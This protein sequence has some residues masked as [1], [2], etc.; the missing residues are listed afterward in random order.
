MVKKYREKPCHFCEEIFT[1]RSSTQRH[2]SILCRFW[3]RVDIRNPFECWEWLGPRVPKGYGH[4]SISSIRDVIAHRYAWEVVNGPI[5][6]DLYVLHECDNRACCNPEHLWLGTQYDNVRD[7]LRKGRKNDVS[8]IRNPRAKLN[9]NDVLK[10]K[11]Q[12]NDGI[13]GCAIALK[14][15]VSHG[16]ISAIKNHRSWF[17][18]T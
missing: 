6:N 18:L 13:K 10:I 8:G 11:Q 15:G 12:I 16:T 7:M 17:H 5:T 2:C 4:F 14:F 9:E 1:P 3:D